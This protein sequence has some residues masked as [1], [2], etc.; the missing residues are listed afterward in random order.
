MKRRDLS[1]GALPNGKGAEHKRRKKDTRST[2]TWYRSKLFV[3][4]VASFVL[5]VVSSRSVYKSEFARV[6]PANIRLIFFFRP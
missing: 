6:S 1:F 3:P 2:K 5:L 4:F